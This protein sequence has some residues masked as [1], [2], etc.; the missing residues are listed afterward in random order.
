MQIT[1]QQILFKKVQG[2]QTVY[3]ALNLADYQYD[4]NFQT[5]LPALVDVLSANQVQVENGSAHI[6]MPPFSAMII[7]SDDIVNTEPEAV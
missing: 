5:H 1:N 7:V 6:H 2:E 3:V 4:F